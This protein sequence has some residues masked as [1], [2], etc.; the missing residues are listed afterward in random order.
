MR[1]AEAKAM[2]DYSP[3]PRLAGRRGEP[4]PPPPAPAS[5][6]AS[7]S[8]RTRLPPPIPLP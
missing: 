7:A 8:A 3:P 2:A 5:A 4:I 1:D 6:S